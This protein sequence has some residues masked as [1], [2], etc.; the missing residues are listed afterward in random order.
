MP[1]AGMLYDIS[2]VVGPLSGAGLVIWFMHR[3]FKKQDEAITAHKAS[4][5]K[6]ASRM[7]CFESAQHACQL[8]N[9]KTFVTKAEHEK[10]EKCVIDHDRRLV[11]METQMDDGK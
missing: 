9:A 2:Q 5:D 8:D 3:G 11:R 4:T 6:I 1:D 10:L 7:D